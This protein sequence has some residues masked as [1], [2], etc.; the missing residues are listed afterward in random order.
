MQPVNPVTKQRRL[1]VYIFVLI[2]CVSYLLFVGAG[3]PT[4][5]GVGVPFSGF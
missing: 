5:G 2:Y 3:F 4:G 1:P